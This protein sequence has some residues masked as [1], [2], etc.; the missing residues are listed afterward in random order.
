MARLVER[1][2]LSAYLSG[3]VATSERWLGWLEHH[4]ALERNALV[5][6]I[7]GVIATAQGRPE[8][9]ERFADVA[10]HA[11]ARTLPNGSPTTLAWLCILRAQRCPRGVARM[12]V[13]AKLALRTPA[14]GGASARMPWSC[15]GS[16]I[17]WPARSTRPTTCSRTLSKRALELGAHEVAMVALGERAAVAIGQGRWVEAEELTE[18]AL[19]VAHRSRLHEYPTSAFV[20]ALAARVGLHRG[21]AQRA[22]ELL[23]R[24][25]RLRAGLTYAIAPL[26]VQCRL[27]LARAYLAVADAGGAETVLRE[28]DA[29][30]RRQ[31][32]LGT[33]PSEVDE[34]RA[35]LKRCAQTPPAPRP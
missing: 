16:R 13:D 18:R 14:V 19:Q 2:A 32:D 17:D 27:E 15:W 4:G 26:A 12:C 33:L 31:P 28:I 8:Q 30:L 25:Q 20:C 1:C 10:E 21:E 5:A 24:A 6:A 9:A 3:R 35:S 22:H 11:Y 23:T 7:G 29:L 34:V